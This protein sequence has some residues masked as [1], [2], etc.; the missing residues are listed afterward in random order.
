[1]PNGSSDEA[2]T[3]MN[4]E[5]AT[6][7]LVDLDLAAVASIVCVMS[8]TDTIVALMEADQAVWIRFGINVDRIEPELASM[9]TEL[10]SGV[11][12]QALSGKRLRGSVNDANV[13][14]E[15]L[16]QYVYIGCNLVVTATKIL[17]ALE[18]RVSM[19][20]G[21]SLSSR[22]YHPDT[23]DYSR[24]GYCRQQPFATV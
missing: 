9:R 19:A 11:I 12:S 15:E 3:S 14:C 20:A 4:P 2:F 24:R 10:E 13:Y 16:N 18:A 23:I 22:R 21:R 6:D 8:D 5:A 17:A 7:I 1:M